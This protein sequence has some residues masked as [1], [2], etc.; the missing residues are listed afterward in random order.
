MTPP[1]KCFPLDVDDLE[2][3]DDDRAAHDPNRH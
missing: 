2:S 3:A 1:R